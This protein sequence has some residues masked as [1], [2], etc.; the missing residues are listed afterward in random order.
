VRQ[1]SREKGAVMDFHEFLDHVVNQR[2]ERSQIPGGDPWRRGQTY[3]NLL[4]TV[5]PGLYA[6]L[7]GSS[8]DP[9]HDDARIPQFLAWLAKEWPGDD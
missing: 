7:V 8:T 3:M 4:Q 1:E 5:R 2:F 6:K 9:F